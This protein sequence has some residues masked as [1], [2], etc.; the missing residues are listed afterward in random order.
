MAYVLQK[1]KLMDAH[2]YEPGFTV[3]LA[4]KDIDLARASVALSP[5]LRVVYDRLERTIASGHGH[6]DLRGRRLR[7]RDGEGL[8][9]R[10][11]MVGGSGE[12]R[13]C[14]S[15]TCLR[16]PANDAPVLRVDAEGGGP[17]S[18]SLS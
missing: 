5:L 15:T 7:Q 11:S 12:R 10:Q 9:H 2:S 1:V 3:D 18:R 17:N 14:R 16:P 13:M 8:G 6:D 4:L